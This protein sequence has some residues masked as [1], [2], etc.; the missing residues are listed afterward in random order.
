MQLK[1]NLSC[2]QINLSNGESQSFEY[3][4]NELIEIEKLQPKIN[5]IIEYIKTD[6]YESLTKQF[7]D[8]IKVE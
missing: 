1:C 4:D 2:T 6:N 3:V 7:E 5:E 8:S